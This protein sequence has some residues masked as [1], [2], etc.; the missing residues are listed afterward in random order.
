M[1]MVNSGS[2]GLSLFA[3]QRVINLKSEDFPA[4]KKTICMTL[5]QCWTNVEG[6][7]PA[8]YKCHTN[9]FGLMGYHLHIYTFNL[10]RSKANQRDDDL[11]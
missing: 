11:E 1:T 8:L 2:K 9:V 3:R 6:V 7:G 10:S 5:A 4:S